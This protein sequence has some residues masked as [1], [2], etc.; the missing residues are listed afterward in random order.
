[1]YD[2]LERNELIPDGNGGVAA[3]GTAK[4]LVAKG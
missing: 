4:L 3:R 2:T 1:M